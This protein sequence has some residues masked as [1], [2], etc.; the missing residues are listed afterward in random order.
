MLKLENLNNVQKQ[1]VIQDIKAAALADSYSDSNLAKIEEVATKANDEI[2]KIIQTINA[3]TNLTEAQKQY[4]LKQLKLQPVNKIDEFAKNLAELE[5]AMEEART[6]IAKNNEELK[7]ST[8]YL[9]ASNQA[10]YNKAA[11]TLQNL[12]EGKFGKDLTG[13]QVKDLVIDFNRAFEGLDGD[14]RLQTAK[15]NAEK[16]LSDLN[17]LSPDSINTAKAKVQAATTLEEIEEVLNNAVDTNTR[18]NKYWDLMEEYEKV[19]ESEV[20]KN[21]EKKYQTNFD[22]ALKNAKSIFSP[23]T[24][25]LN[26]GYGIF[27][28]QQLEHRVIMAYEML[29]TDFEQYKKNYAD[30]I[31]NLD[32]LSEGQKQALID[33]INAITVDSYENRVAV[34]NVYSQADFL[35]TAMKDMRAQLPK[36][37]D[38]NSIQYKI[39]SPDVKSAYDEVAADVEKALGNDSKNTILDP[40]KIQQLTKDIPT[41]SAALNGEENYQNKVINPTQALENISSET[42]NNFLKKADEQAAKSDA[43]LAKMEELVSQFKQADAA[44]GKLNPYLDKWDDLQDDLNFIN[45]SSDQKQAV[46]DAINAIKAQIVAAQNLQIPNDELIQ[47]LQANYDKAVANLDGYRNMAKEAVAEALYLGEQQ[48]QFES[49]ANTMDST[50]TAFNNLIK[51]MFAQSQT[52]V[53]AILDTS[54]LSDTEKEEFIKEVDAAQPAESNP[55][56]EPLSVIYD[57]YA[58]IV[59]ARKKLAEAIQNSSFSDATKEQLTNEGK[60]LTTPAEINE[61]ADRISDLNIEKI[62]AEELLKQAQENIKDPLF[63]YFNKDEATKLQ[64]GAT[65]LEQ[66]LNDLE[67]GLTAANINQKLSDLTT[68]STTVQTQNNLFNAQKQKIADA[69]QVVNNALYLTNEDKETLKNDIPNIDF[70]KENWLTEW[71]DKVFAQSVANV[72]SLINTSKSLTQTEKDELLNKVKQAQVSRDLALPVDQNLKEIVESIKQKEQANDESLKAGLGNLQNISQAQKDAFQEELDQAHTMDEKLQI[73]QNANKLDEKLGQINQALKDLSALEKDINYTKADQ[74]LQQAVQDAKNELNNFIDKLNKTP[75]KSADVQATVGNINGLE[76]SLNNAISNLNG[77]KNFTTQLINASNILSD[78]QKA[79]ATN[80]YQEKSPFSKSEMIDALNNA[81]QV[82]RENVLAEL[83]KLTNLTPTQVAE[84]KEQIVK[85]TISTTDGEAFDIN[86]ENIL[87]A[88]KTTNDVIN[89]AKDQIDKLPNLTD[90]EKETIKDQINNANSKEE[91]D[92]IVDNAN[93]L[94]TAL[95]NLNKDLNDYLNTGDKTNVNKDLEDIKDHLIKDENGNVVTPIEDINNLVSAADQ[96]LDLQKALEEYKASNPSLPNYNQTKQNLV[97]AINKVQTAINNL[98]NNNLVGNLK[99]TANKIIDKL[100]DLSSEGNNL[101]DL[102]NNIQNKNELGT[103]LALTNQSDSWSTELQEWLT[104]NNYF[105][106]V[107]KVD[108]KITK[109][110]IKDLINQ[111]KGMNTLPNV[112]K[113]ALIKNLV[114]LDLSQKLWWLLSLIPVGLLILVGFWWLILAKRKKNDEEEQK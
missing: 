98:K 95:D 26:V 60:T 73:I 100:N 48:S 70:T 68:S 109:A 37:V 79:S 87:E 114:D 51:E 17:K 2:A 19:K 33:Q 74:N 9:L 55:I 91:V 41:K 103:N 71:Q 44:I 38:K 101:L 83:D 96:V 45:A 85:A 105:N 14:K 102:V 22:N 77:Y 1:G 84:Y 16:A 72:N 15:E 66:K 97:D 110:E 56:D 29:L 78:E 54:L 11:T 81:M 67:N 8:N 53:K 69:L 4:Q 65:D 39:S 7:Q 47:Q 35:N 52:N 57:K 50:E 21:A 112:V 40:A 111:L 23:E 106:I 36:M 30:K 88:A 86:L 46:T 75:I 82:S 99:D 113:E 6:A 43:T 94:D 92:K 20:Y 25:L 42:M 107:N 89:S 3:S 32:S 5:S 90:S 104:K 80:S 61:F 49:K 93:G 13:A 108:S 63:N 28:M 76:T 24:H 62:K 34:A 58:Q 10:A 59:E 12:V 31:K 64:N 18:A 27:E